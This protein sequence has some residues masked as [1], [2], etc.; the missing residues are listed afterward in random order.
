M[1]V[2][3]ILE[4]TTLSIEV[5]KGVDKEGNTLYGKKTF[6]GIKN[7]ADIEKIN[8]VAEGI[9]SVLNENTRYFYVTETSVIQ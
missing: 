8:A 3:K 2:N 9:S 5:E 4:T 7:N 1:A 6:S